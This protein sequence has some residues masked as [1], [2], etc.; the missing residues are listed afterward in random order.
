MGG[1][2]FELPEYANGFM[3]EMYFV[4]TTKE[5]TGDTMSMIIKDIQKKSKTV[6]MQN[7]QLMNLSG[8][9]KN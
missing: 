9:M 4:G 7:Y 5:N 1:N 2:N 3:L 8:L 6:T